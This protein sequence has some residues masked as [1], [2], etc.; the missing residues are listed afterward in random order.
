MHILSPHMILSDPSIIE[1]KCMPC[2]RHKILHDLRIHYS[3]Y[4]HHFASLER[5]VCVGDSL[6]AS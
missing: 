5:H 6:R 2:W 1:R 3:T 4:I